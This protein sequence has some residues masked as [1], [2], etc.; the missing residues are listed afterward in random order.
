[1]DIMQNNNLSG[2]PTPVNRNLRCTVF[3]EGS[4]PNASVPGILV[5][6]TCK[7]SIGAKAEQFN[8]LNTNDYQPNNSSSLRGVNGPIGDK[9]ACTTPKPSEFPPNPEGFGPVG[10]DGII[11]NEFSCVRK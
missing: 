8:G 4:L 5:N 3:F 2:T 1:M 11:T 10:K 6:N 9:I 7:V